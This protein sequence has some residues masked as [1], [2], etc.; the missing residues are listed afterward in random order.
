[1]DPYLLDRR[2]EISRH[3]SQG[4]FDIRLRLHTKTF[5]AVSFAKQ[6]VEINKI[7]ANL[8]IIN[9]IWSQNYILWNSLASMYLEDCNSDLDGIVCP[10]GYTSVQHFSYQTLETKALL[11]SCSASRQTQCTVDTWFFFICAL[12][13]SNFLSGAWTHEGMIE[14][15]FL[16][17]Y[18]FLLL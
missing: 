5:Q 18:L 10:P 6:D 12:S 16:Y 7:S 9:A 4:S 8:G 1:M 3:W 15:L 17:R 13:N 14:I 11:T 2:T